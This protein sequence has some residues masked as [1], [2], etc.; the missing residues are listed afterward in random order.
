MLTLRPDLV[1]LD[2]AV[3]GFMGELSPTVLRT[4][5]AEGIHVISPNGILGD[6]RGMSASLGAACIAATAEMMADCF[7]AAR[8][9]RETVAG[10]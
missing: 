3:P 2:R 8:R 4:M 6:P 5:F 7:V 10:R 1:H 9:E